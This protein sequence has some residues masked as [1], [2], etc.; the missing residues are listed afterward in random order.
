MKDDFDSGGWT[1]LLIE[2]LNRS[3]EGCLGSQGA[4]LSRPSR[5]LYTDFQ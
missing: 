4:F 2:G 1:D 5:P 3:I